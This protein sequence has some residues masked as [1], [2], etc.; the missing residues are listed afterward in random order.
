MGRCL[1]FSGLRGFKTLKEPR[2]T[3]G[4]TLLVLYGECF[5]LGLSVGVSKSKK[6]IGSTTPVSL[7]RMM[8]VRVQCVCT[9]CAYYVYTVCS[10]CIWYVYTI[11]I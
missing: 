6:L 1:G 4:S 10:V 9:V 3:L 11:H 2:E 8:C 7:G 5:S